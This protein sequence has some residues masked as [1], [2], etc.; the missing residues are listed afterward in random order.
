M[1]QKCPSSHSALHKQREIMIKGRNR[2]FEVFFL[3]WFDLVV[4]LT[5]SVSGT[6]SRRCWRCLS[7]RA[8]ALGCR[9]RVGAAARGSRTLSAVIPAQGHEWGHAVA[10]PGSTGRWSS[11]AGFGRGWF[12]GPCSGGGFCFQGQTRR[13][14][15][16]KVEQCALIEV[17]RLDGAEVKRRRPCGVTF[18]FV[19]FPDKR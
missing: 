4:W 16:C 2:E 14:Q 15:V 12:H 5:T 17:M 19:R 13:K 11:S 6:S 1:L 18:I 10:Q 7:S 9:D 8:A 3:I